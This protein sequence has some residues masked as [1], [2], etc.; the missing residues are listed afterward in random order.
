MILLL[1]AAA[2]ATPTPAMLRTF[3]DWTVGCDN[4]RACHATSLMPEEGDWDEPLTL[5]VKREAGADASPVVAA[6]TSAGT[7]AALAVDG[8]KLP[9][10]LK[11]QDEE[12][13]IEGGDAAATIASLRAAS[14]VTFQDATGK[15]LGTVSLK[16]LTAALLY[17]DDAQKRVGTTTALART[18]DKPASTVPPAPPL[19]VVRSAFDKAAAAISVP[20]AR[21]DT[22]RKDS[23][24]E[25][26]QPSE[27]DSADVYPLDSGHSL[28]LLSCGAGAYNLSSVPFIVT[29]QGKTLAIAPAQFDFKP[30]WSESGLPMLV[31]GDWVPDEGVLTSFPKGRGIGDCGSGSDYAW[32]GTRFRLIERMQMDE[33]RGSLDYITTWRAKVER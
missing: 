3:Q 23:K 14:A 15:S 33:C 26:E 25:I 18:G 1:A 31:N 2:A 5:A 24:C 32:D 12:Q 11:L 22:L 17:I 8:R 16:G 4:G 6:S 9:V 20:K 28:L 21:I 13:L 19:P 27:M 10:H 7:V 29:R 30:A